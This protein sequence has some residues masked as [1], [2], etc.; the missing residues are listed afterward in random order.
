MLGESQGAR[1]R[2]DTGC[3]SRPQEDSALL[4]PRFLTSGSQSC[5]GA[6]FCTSRACNSGEA[7]HRCLLDSRAL[8]VFFRK[9]CLQRTAC[10]VHSLAC[11]RRRES[12]CH[13]SEPSSRGSASELDLEIPA[14]SLGRE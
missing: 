9:S 7:T 8:S 11:P 2:R 13:R 1:K 4:T 5:A 12:R 10:S 3:L 6:N 14:E